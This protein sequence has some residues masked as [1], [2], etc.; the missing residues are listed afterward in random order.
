MKIYLVR[1]G[2]TDWN[3]ERRL[4]G[5]KDIPMNRHG[6]SQIE[7]IGDYMSDCGYRIDT[8]ISSPL[9]RA[10]MSAE[11]I[12]SRIGYEKSRIIIDPLF[13]E[14]SF[15]AAE[16]MIRTAEMCLDDGKYGEESVEELCGRA[17]DG[18]KKYIAEE[19]GNVLLV[20]HGA[21]LKAVIVALAQGKIAYNDS[22][23]QIV[24][25][26]ILCVEYEGGKGC[27]INLLFQ[28]GR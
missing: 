8:I 27:L 1:H 16:G 25:G 22:C 9:Q 4:Q 10:R 23:G 15:G 7:K 14:R 24:Q 13:T 19:S 11:I 17:A 2:E 20:A 3:K 21:I 6:I 18:V 26:G 12:A 28:T 5:N